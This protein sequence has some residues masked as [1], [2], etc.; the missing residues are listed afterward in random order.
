MNCTQRIGT[1]RLALAQLDA[2]LELLRVS[3]LGDP[4]TP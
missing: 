4:H 3:N 1:V 2:A